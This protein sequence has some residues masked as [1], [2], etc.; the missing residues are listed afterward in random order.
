MIEVSIIMPA[1]NASQFISESINSVINQ[2]FTNWELIIIDDG[3]TDNTREIV[4]TFVVTDNRIKYLWQQNGKQSKAR[5]YGISISKGNWIAFLDAD[6]FWLPEKLDRQLRTLLDYK[7]DFAFSNGFCLD[8]ETRLTTDYNSVNG[9]FSGFELYRIIYKHNYIPI[10]SVI[11]RRSLINKIGLF[12]ENLLVQGCE[13]WDYWLRMCKS[14]TKFL[15]MDERL[16]TYRVHKS[17]TS[18][19]LDKM[20]I[21]ICYVLNINLYNSFLTQLEL[22]SAKERLVNLITKILPCLYDK[23]DV[24]Y[25]KYFINVGVRQTHS[26]C[27]IIAKGLVKVLGKK[28]RKL[29]IYIIK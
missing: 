27:F 15:G 19:N 16:F 20:Y 29:V 2:T 9:I 3:S 24:K 22:N 13:D 7:V 1:Y 17:S 14:D 6:D 18:Q 5:N 23:G 21:A 8:Q 28:S 11:F 4:Q 10:L 25:I 12:D 26:I